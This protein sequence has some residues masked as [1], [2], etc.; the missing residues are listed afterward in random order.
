MSSKKKSKKKTTTGAG[1]NTPMLGV[2]SYT[3]TSNK[4]NSQNNDSSLEGLEQKTMELKEKLQKIKSDA[5]QERALNLEE[6]YQLNSDITDKNFEINVL[7]GENRDLIAQLKE[8]K[9]SLDE[10]M[11]IGNKFLVKM[12]KLK[13]EEEHKKKLIE[14]K[15]KEI[16][17]A[18]KNQDIAIRDYNRIKNISD[19]NYPD[20]EN[21]LRKNLES[22]END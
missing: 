12:E 6:T 10:K 2:P 20:K 22:L 15:D 7:S 16:E 17:L 21:E 14:V 4:S 8:I 11:K 1:I 5:E 18:Q 13:K 3:Q 9:N 19:N